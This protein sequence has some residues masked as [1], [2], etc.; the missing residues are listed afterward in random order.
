[1]SVQPETN[2][3]GSATSE[4]PKERLERLLRRYLMTAPGA[5]VSGDAGR[6]TDV[7]AMVDAIEEMIDDAVRYHVED[8]PHI[9]PDGS[10][11]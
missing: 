2:R 1:M 3:L 11:A 10:M 5:V 9:Y 8:E 4:R 7:K 6:D